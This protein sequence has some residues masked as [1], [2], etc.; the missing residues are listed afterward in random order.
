VGKSLGFQAAEADAETGL[1][2]KSAAWAWAPRL[3]TRAYAP[4]GIDSAESKGWAL[5]LQGWVRASGSR[6]EAPAMGLF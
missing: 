2:F 4:K 3:Q 5:R 6:F 1:D